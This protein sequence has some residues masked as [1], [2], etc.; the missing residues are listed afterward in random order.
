[1]QTL[2]YFGVGGAL[3]A[4]GNTTSTTIN[5]S[6]FS[7]WLP[8]VAMFIAVIAGYVQLS[9]AVKSN[10]QT[11]EKNTQ[12]L[13]K[14]VDL[15]IRDAEQAEQIATLRRDMNVMWTTLDKHMAFEGD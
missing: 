15:Q 8:A 6:K 4:N 9:E 14:L 2:D 13:S 10:S 5:L 1:M 11:I 7:Q 12:L 3:M